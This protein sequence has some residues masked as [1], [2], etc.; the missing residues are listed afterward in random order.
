MRNRGIEQLAS[1][2]PN[3]PITRLLNPGKD[4]AVVPLLT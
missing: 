2:A 3:Y 4:L 1:S